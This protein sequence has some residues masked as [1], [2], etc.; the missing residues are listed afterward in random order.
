MAIFSDTSLEVEQLHSHNCSALFVTF[1]FFLCL[2]PYDNGTIDIL[3]LESLRI[4]GKQCIPLSLLF[5]FY[6][7]IFLIISSFIGNEFVNQ[8]A[9]GK[10]HRLPQIGVLFGQISSQQRLHRSNGHTLTLFQF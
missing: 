8:R 3:L 2:Y 4:A 7:Y 9:I 5:Y 10:N 6:L 1:L